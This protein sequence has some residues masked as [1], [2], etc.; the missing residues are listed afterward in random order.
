MKHTSERELWVNVIL[1]AT[2]DGLADKQERKWF[3]LTNP[4]FVEVCAL[5]DLD[6]EAVADRAASA[7]ERYDQAEASGTNFEI[8]RPLSPAPRPVARYEHAGRLM[9]LS[10]WAEFTSININTIRSRLDSG[11]SFKE[12]IDPAFRPKPRR[13]NGRPGRKPQRHT[14]NGVS[15]TLTEWAVIYDVNHRSLAQRLRQG[16]T[17]EHAL[18]HLSSG[19]RASLLHTVDGMSKT[20]G[21]WADHLGI[22]YDAFL[23]RLR[24]GNRTVAEAV[25][26]GGPRRRSFPRPMTSTQG[27]GHDLPDR[28]GTGGRSAARDRAEIEFSEKP[29][30]A[31]S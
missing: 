12:A 25:A 30:K 27:V 26:M 19:K 14:V 1:R 21:E 18:A 29:E 3:Q 4:D 5:A 17:L 6:P 22:S 23:K 15:K 31:H 10:E 9:T 7:F 28:F 8:T 16:Q 2:E 13:F 24:D 20:Y 11:R